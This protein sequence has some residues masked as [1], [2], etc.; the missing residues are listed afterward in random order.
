[1][2]SIVGLISVGGI[3]LGAYLGFRQWRNAKNKTRLDLY[4]KR[5]EV[6]RCTEE[7]LS[8]AWTGNYD[9]GPHLLAAFYHCKREA[10]FLF[11][12]KLATYIDSLYEGVEDHFNLE[13][14]LEIEGESLDFDEREGLQHRVYGSRAWLGQQNMHLKEKFAK[15]L[16]L[17]AIK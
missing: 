2:T 12:K 4:P 13:L 17:S 9:Y 10:H 11:D 5:I 8:R 6:F 3:L 1:M 16:D 7:F 15:Y 14:K